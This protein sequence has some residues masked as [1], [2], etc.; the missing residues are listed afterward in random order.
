MVLIFRPKWVSTNISNVN[1]GPGVQSSV[2]QYRQH[3]PA[4]NLSRTHHFSSSSSLAP[5]ASSST[6]SCGGSGFTVGAKLLLALILAPNFQN[7]TGIGTRISATQPRSV[8]AHSTPRASNMYV[9]NRG[10]R[11]PAMERRKVFAA[12]AEAALM[13]HAISARWD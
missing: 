6:L 8:P 4:Q 10:K 3:N 13:G 9:E 7:T 1:Y 5:P 2:V 11:A 12:M